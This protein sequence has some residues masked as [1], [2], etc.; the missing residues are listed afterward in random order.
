MVE[1]R[2]L[3]NLLLVQ[4]K[5]NKKK[6]EPWLMS[7]LSYITTILSSLTKFFNYAVHLLGSLSIGSINDGKKFHWHYYF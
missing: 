3:G 2:I 5:K 7:F 1:E 4:E 6:K